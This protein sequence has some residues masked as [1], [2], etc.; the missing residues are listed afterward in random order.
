MGFDL[1]L[2]FDL[3]NPDKIV[4]ATGNTRQLKHNIMLKCI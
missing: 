3:N 1:G 2:L 4:G